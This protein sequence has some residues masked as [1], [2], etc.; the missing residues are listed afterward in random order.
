MSVFVRLSG[1][2]SIFLPGSSAM[3]GDE[4]MMRWEGGAEKCDGR[5][6]AERGAPR[7]MY[8]GRALCCLPAPGFFERHAILCDFA[9]RMACG[10]NAEGW[11]EA[12]VRMDGGLRA[13][14]PPLSF[15]RRRLLRRVNF[16]DDRG[17]QLSAQMNKRMMRSP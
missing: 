12:P 2:T 14:L 6:M 10:W 5:P 3:R 4:G 7:C 1:C 16:N 8:K 13:R 9:R 17:E 11:E 15:R